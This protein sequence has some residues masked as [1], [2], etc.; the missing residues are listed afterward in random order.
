MEE[1]IKIQGGLKAPKSQ[2]NKFGNYNYRNAEDI[3]EALKPLLTENNCVLTLS[4][5]IEM[6]GTRYYVRATAALSNSKGEIASVN[7]YAREEEIKKGMDGAQ[8]TGSASSYARKYALNGL[9]CIDDTKDPDST[10][11]HGK[12]DKEEPKQEDPDLIIAVDEAKRAKTVEELQ[13]VW[14]NW[15]GYQSDMMFKNT[16][17][18]LKK[19]LANGK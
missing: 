13:A 15:K 6:I 10:N 19:T 8:I 16:V 18:T 9:F 4:D 17:L 5:T 3:L 1:L 14:N 12:E 11:K 7:A 2:F